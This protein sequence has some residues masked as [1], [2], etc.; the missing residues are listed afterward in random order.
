[1]QFL[2]DACSNISTFSE[3]NRVELLKQKPTKRPNWVDLM[4]E[5]GEFKYGFGGRLKKTKCNDRSGPILSTTKVGDN[6]RISQLFQFLY[7]VFSFQI[8]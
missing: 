1:M 5:I 6:V 7:N 8:M 4:S 3:S 2:L